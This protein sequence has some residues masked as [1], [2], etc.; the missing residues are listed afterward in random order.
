VTPDNFVLQMFRIPNPGAPA[1]FL[2]HG[3][4]DSADTW[5][6]N[7]RNSS[8]AYILADAGYDVWMGNSRGNKYSRNNTKLSPNWPF[9]A[10]FW[11]FSF[12]DM[13]QYDVPTQVNHLL[14]VTG[15]PQVVYIGHSQGTTQAF[16]NFANPQWN[17][18]NQIS[19]FIALAPVCYVEHTTSILLKAIADLDIDK[20]VAFFGVHEFLPTST[21]LRWLLPGVCAVTPVLCDSVIYL[22]AGLDLGDL[23][24][25]RMDVYMS[26]FPSGTSVMNM[27]HWSQEVRQND[28]QM[29]DYGLLNKEHYG[30]STPPPYRLDLIA[31]PPI[32]L[33]WGGQDDLADNTDVAQLIA[34]APPST[35]VYQNY[36]AAY[37]HLDFVWGEHANVE[38]YPQVLWLIE[39]YTTAGQAY[40]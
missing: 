38:I 3:L 36:T 30:T 24:Q 11:T 22:F 8:L 13:A 17:I 16:A 14:S 18:S 26:H 33:F 5:L 9:D 31:S 39:Q 25:T 10:P 28:F 29:Y 34:Q 19:L 2:Q 37:G 15:H 32:A 4:L 1:V 7:P 35:I 21:F 6:V 12:D 40:A 20:I 27:E 23:N